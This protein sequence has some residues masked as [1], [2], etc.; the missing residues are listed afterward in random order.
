[1]KERIAQSA[2]GEIMQ[3]GLKFSIRDVAARLGISTKS[4]YQFFDSKEQII[5][6]LVDR[7]IADMRDAEKE[8]MDDPVLTPRQKLEKAL[9]ILPRGIVFPD[10]RV[11]HEVKVKYPNQW[12][13][14]DTY[15][16]Q[17]WDNIRMLVREGMAEGSL[18]PFDLDVF[19]QM[20]IGAL[21]HLMDYR[22]STRMGLSL[23]KALV[24][25]VEIMLQGIEN[26]VV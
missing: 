11:L 17:G 24:Q 18:R 5:G 16:E 9:V 22:V 25:M 13:K 15:L 14:A 7:C 10:I 6:Y 19:I 4:I 2:I 1:M 26:K 8:V 23:E 12:E 20:Y 21:N 3:R